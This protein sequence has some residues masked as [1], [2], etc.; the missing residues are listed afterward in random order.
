MEKKVRLAERMMNFL[1]E[2][3][4]RELK[5]EGETFDLDDFLKSRKKSW[6]CDED[7]VELGNRINARLRKENS[8][9]I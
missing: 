6:I 8:K 1:V 9:C 3:Y 2:E 4:I 7:Y 5:E